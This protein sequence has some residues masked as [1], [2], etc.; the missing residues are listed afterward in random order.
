MA[1][2]PRSVLKIHGRPYTPTAEGL[3]RAVEA[4]GARP[5]P[6]GAVW[7]Q[8]GGAKYPLREVARL[9]LDYQGPPVMYLKHA[10]AFARSLGLTTGQEPGEYRSS[11]RPPRG[12]T[13]ES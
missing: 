6:P 13:R 7:V 4:I 5:I 1:M 9:A 2:P 11:G 3:L 12:H 8:V 10:Q